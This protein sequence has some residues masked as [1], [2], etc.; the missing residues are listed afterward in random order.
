M[1][2][3]TDAATQ[4]QAY[5]VYCTCPEDVTAARLAATLVQEGLAACANRIPGMSSTYRWQGAVHTDTEVLLLLKTT[6]TRYPDLERRILALHPY[7]LPEIVAVPVQAGLP[8]YLAWVAQ[9]VSGSTDA[10]D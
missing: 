3:A 7:E 9:S 4:S 1:Q 5:L 6:A 2:A 10:S 8:G